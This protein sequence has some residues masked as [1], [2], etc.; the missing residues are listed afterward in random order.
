MLTLPFGTRQIVCSVRQHMSCRVN[1]RCFTAGAVA[2]VQ[3][4]DGLSGKRRLQ[5][6]TAQIFGKNGNG[7]FICF[8]RQVTANFTFQLRKD[9]PFVTVCSC[10]GKDLTIRRT[11]MHDSLGQFFNIE[12]M[13]GSQRYFQQFLRFAAIDGQNPVT[14]QMADAFAEIFIGSHGR[15]IGFFD[16]QRAG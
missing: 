3:A 13:V 6:E 8:F 2:R 5:Q 14:G 9:E 11:A 15:R 7:L 1:D 12:I 10:R 4:Q 16:L